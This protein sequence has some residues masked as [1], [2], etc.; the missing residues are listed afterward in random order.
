MDQQIVD[1]LQVE[2]LLHFCEG[3]PEYVEDKH[4]S[5]QYNVNCAHDPLDLLHTMP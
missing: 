2:A 3:R 4:S 1:G 5:E